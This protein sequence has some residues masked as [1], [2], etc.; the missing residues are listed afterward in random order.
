MVCYATVSVSLDHGTN[1]FQTLISKVFFCKVY[2]AYASSKLYEF[3][4]SITI[5]SILIIV[6]R[7]F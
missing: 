1:S 3:I 4:V 7:F 6:A 5:L 2:P